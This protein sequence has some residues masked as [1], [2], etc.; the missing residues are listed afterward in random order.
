MRFLSYYCLFVITGAAFFVYGAV[1]GVHVNGLTWHDAWTA[2]AGRIVCIT[3]GI[4]P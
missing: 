2:P 3:K 1:W 4:G